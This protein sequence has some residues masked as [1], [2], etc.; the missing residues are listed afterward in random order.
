MLMLQPD[1]K[2]VKLMKWS[3]KVQYFPLKQQKME[4]LKFYLKYN[5]SENVFSYFPQM[6]LYVDQ[7]FC[8]PLRCF[9]KLY[10]ATWYVTAD[11]L[12]A[13][14]RAGR[15]WI[16]LH[17]FTLVSKSKCSSGRTGQVTVSGSFVCGRRDFCSEY[18]DTK[19][20]LHVSCITTVHFF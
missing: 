13:L 10:R 11:H 3:K 7:V 6:V 9:V 8:F 1:T 17:S 19:C 5:A 2:V 20:I 14:I 4:T 18:S 15:R 16:S 12:T